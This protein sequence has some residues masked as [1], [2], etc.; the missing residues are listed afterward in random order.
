MRA[1]QARA[2]AIIIFQLPYLSR[3]PRG[4]CRGER[5]KGVGGGRRGVRLAELESETLALPLS[6]SCR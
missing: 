1:A 2:V 5:E 4:E 3:G 6:L